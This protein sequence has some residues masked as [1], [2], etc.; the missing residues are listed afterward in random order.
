MILNQI[1]NTKKRYTLYLIT[2]FAFANNTFAQNTA[3]LDECYEWARAAFPL[4]Q[5]KDIIAANANLQAKNVQLM[6]LPQ[7]S[8]NAQATYQSDVSGLP[9]TLKIPG[10]EIKS[11]NQDQYKATLDIQQI[12]WDGGVIAQ[13]K[14]NISANSATDLQRVE[15]EAYKI[16]ERVNTLFFTILQIDENVKLIKSVDGDLETRIKKVAAMIENGTSLKSPLY[17]LQAEQ[18]KNEQR[19]TELNAQRSATIGMLN[20]LTN[21]TFAANTV[22]TNVNTVNIAPDLRVLRP[23]LQFFD[24]QNKA[25]GQ[26]VKSTSLKNMPKLVAFGTLGYGNP[27]LNFLKNEFAP[28][29]I[30]GIQFK[31]NLQDLYNPTI[32]NEVAILKANQKMT[33]LQRDLFVQNTQI[34]AKQYSEEIVKLD[35]LII[36][37]KKIIAL[38]EKIKASAAAQVDNGVMTTSDYLLELSAETQAKQNL[39]LHEIQLAAAEVYLKTVLGE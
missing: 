8:F 25:I 34:A 37:D 20:V 6:Y 10:I 36:T 16:R 9:A 7:V 12:I 30:G 23:E 1:F 33:D 3:T 5:Q 28:Y 4:L 31:W 15:V 26:Q 24:L 39:I 22:F 32:K 2:I 13:Q 35:A 29:G 11:V 14:N 38:R 21:K 17:S 27:G 19:L 18:L